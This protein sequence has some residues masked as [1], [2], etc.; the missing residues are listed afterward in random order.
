VNS[1]FEQ[2]LRMQNGPESPPPCSYALGLLLYV[3]GVTNG[4]IQ[5]IQEV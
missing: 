5:Y 1:M 4:C 2:Q 3:Q